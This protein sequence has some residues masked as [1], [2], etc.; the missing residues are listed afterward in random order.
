MGFSDVHVPCLCL[1]ALSIVHV[2]FR[3]PSAIQ[4]RLLDHLGP[5][6]GAVAKMFVRL[7][8]LLLG[9]PPRLD[10]LKYVCDHLLLPDVNEVKLVRGLVA[11]PLEETIGIMEGEAPVAVHLPFS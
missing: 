5:L 10:C 9:S 1:C 11:D 2:A 7:V 6:E 4:E 3:H 8:E